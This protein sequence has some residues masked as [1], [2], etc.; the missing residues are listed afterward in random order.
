MFGPSRLGWPAHLGEER[1]ITVG[2]SLTALFHHSRNFLELLEAVQRRERQPVIV[3]WMS[4]QLTVGGL[5][6]AWP[7]HQ[8]G[9]KGKWK[10]FWILFDPV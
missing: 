4:Q 8:T 10:L 9:R 3:S 2:V 7:T 1:G 5:K 6:H